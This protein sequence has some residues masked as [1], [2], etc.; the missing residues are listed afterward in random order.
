MLRKNGELHLR[1]RSQSQKLLWG[2]RNFWK[3]CK[4]SGSNSVVK[5]STAHAISALLKTNALWQIAATQEG[6]IPLVSM[7]RLRLPY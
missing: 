6:L 1:A 5:E 3:H 2:L 7:P 4:A